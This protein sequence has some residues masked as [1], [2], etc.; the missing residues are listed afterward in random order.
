M[1]CFYFPL[2]ALKKI[3][4]EIKERE[5]ERDLERKPRAEPQAWASGKDH[6]QMLDIN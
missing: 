1:V 3:N 5:R 2:T 4:N 6:L